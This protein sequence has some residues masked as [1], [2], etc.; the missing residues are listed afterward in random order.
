MIDLREHT[1]RLQRLEQSAAEKAGLRIRLMDEATLL[2]K[3]GKAY[4][5]DFTETILAD[6]G[7]EVKAAAELGVE[8]GAAIAEAK[9]AKAT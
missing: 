7:P 8:L 4:V 6:I 5:Q 1:L 3:D 9:E 2:G